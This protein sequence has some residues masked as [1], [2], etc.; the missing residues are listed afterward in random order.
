MTDVPLPAIRMNDYTSRGVD[1]LVYDE[2][3]FARMSDAEV[4][5]AIQD[6]RMYGSI[7]IHRRMHV[8]TF[9]RR[10]ETRL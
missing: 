2:A 6:A 9:V 5:G 4:A 3:A 7:E 1:V 10:G 8:A